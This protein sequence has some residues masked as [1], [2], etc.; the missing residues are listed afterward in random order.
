MLP[1]VYITPNFTPNAVRFIEA[2]TSL[3]DIKIIV[4]SQE[5]VGLLPYWQQSRISISRQLPDVFN[6]EH[7][8]SILTDIQEITGP[9]HRVIGATE[10]LQV[11]IAEVREA[12]NTDGMDRNTAN[13]FRD[14][15]QMKLLF[16]KAGI[17]CARHSMVHHINEAYLFAETCPYP[18]VLKP[19]EGAGSQTTYRV[20]NAEETIAPGKQQ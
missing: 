15:S 3:Y 13:N 6:S 16:D 12:F 20:N 1:V 17:P 2:L 11:P 8:I 10:Q 9:F 19:V 14:K 5:P 18:F 4:L 7:L